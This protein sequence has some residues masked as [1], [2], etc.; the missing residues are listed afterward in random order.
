MFEIQSGNTVRCHICGSR[1]LMDETVLRH[2]REPGL[3][4]GT[5]EQP[6]RQYILHWWKYLKSC[7]ITFVYLHFHYLMQYT[8][9]RG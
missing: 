6:A 8:Q 5:G 1:M 4:P 7:T 2:A 9:G 3:C